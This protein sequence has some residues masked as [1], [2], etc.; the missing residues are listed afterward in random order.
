MTD[1]ETPPS[2]R[3]RTRA[4]GRAR[5]AQKAA[6]C[7]GAFDALAAGFSPQQIAE[8]RKVSVKTVKRE[9]DRAIAERRLDGPDRYAHLQ[10]ARLTKALRLA[11]ALVDRG[12]VRGLG[13]LVKIVGELDRYH[14]LERRS[15]RIPR[16]PQF[17]APEPQPA[18]PL[19]LTHAAPPLDAAEPEFAVETELDG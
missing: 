15:G 16:L 10:V 18:A 1:D 12:D 13:P 14:G 8:V 9:I 11:D 5:R 17:E 7:E 3:A 2:E 6:L 4:A 19:A